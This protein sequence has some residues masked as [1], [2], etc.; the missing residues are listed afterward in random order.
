[1]ILVMFFFLFFFLFSFAGSLKIKLDDGSLVTIVVEQNLFGGL[2]N[3][4]EHLDFWLRQSGISKRY[5]PMVGRRRDL[6]FSRAE[7]SS[8]EDKDREELSLPESVDQ[9]RS[10]FLQFHRIRLI[11]TI[12]KEQELSALQSSTQELAELERERENCQRELNEA[13][14]ELFVR[15]SKYFLKGKELL[16]KYSITSSKVQKLTASSLANAYEKL[17]GDF[18]KILEQIEEQEERVAAGATGASIGI[19]LFIHLFIHFFIYYF[20]LS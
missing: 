6:R 12:P 20:F 14:D 17:R 11:A 7:S 8:G 1:M 18:A 5:S 16:E 3:A 15:Q 13:R 10:A 2:A 19:Y 9:L 4:A